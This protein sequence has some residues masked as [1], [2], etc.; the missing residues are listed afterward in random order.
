MIFDFRFNGTR[1]P[2]AIGA[3]WADL[4]GSRVGLTFKFGAVRSA[5][6]RTKQIS[7][8]K[9]QAPNSKFKITSLWP[10][11]DYLMTLAQRAN[12]Q[13]PAKCELHLR[14]TYI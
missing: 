6:W 8:S 4:R 1:T 11:N 10:P 5:N 9:H 12:D 3:D 13:L 14:L 7:N 2:I